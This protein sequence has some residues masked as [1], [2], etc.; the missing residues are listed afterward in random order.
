MAAFTELPLEPAL[1]QALEVLEFSSMT[2]VQEQSLPAL[3]DGKDVIAQ[4]RTGSGKTAAFGLALLSR[5]DIAAARVQA[6]V[7]CPTRELANQVSEALRR[8]GRFK[9][10]LKVVTLCG[11]VPARTQAPSLQRP[12]HVV[13]GTPGRIL[14]H[15]QRGNLDLAQLRVLVLDEADRMLD[16][17]F[18]DDIGHVA[19]PTPADRQTLLFSATFPDPIRQL[20]RQFQKT[21]VEVT[22][23]TEADQGTIEQRFY[24][25]EAADKVDAVAALVGQF[26]PAS[27]L[28]FCHTK[29]DTKEVCAQLS[30]RGFSVLALHGDME[31]RD[32]D[33]VM[34]RFANQSCRL[35]VATDV[36]ARG[37]DVKALGAVISYELPDRPDVHV[38]RIGR[39]GRA[40]HRGLALALCA[41]RE[42][43]RVHAIEDEQGA[44]V[45]WGEVDEDAGRRGPSTG[46]DGHAAHQGR[47]EGQGPAR[48]PAR[49]PHRRRRIAGER[50]GQDQRAGQTD[51]RGHPTGGRRQGFGGAGPTQ[52]Q[53]SFVP[54]P[55]R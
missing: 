55:A 10:N 20:S 28:I 37:L 34:L 38:H 1:L 33:E 39:T 16:M 22:V 21:P 5:M 15:M 11:G 19:R 47:Q 12:P 35:L 53:G 23:A 26:Q 32:R 24:K 49:R 13:V 45:T 17:G 52:D 46:A 9:A 18:S 42:Q 2:P 43:T 44:P 7:L 14:D 48:R 50:R 36:A 31:Q 8:L 6:L 40:G 30:A 4:A 51:L 3:L 41:E 25:V 54:R 27:A 29:K